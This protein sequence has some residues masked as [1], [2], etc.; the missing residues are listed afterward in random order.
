MRLARALLLAC[1]LLAT[2]AVASETDVL[3]E[4]EGHLWAG[5]GGIGI[6][7][8]SETAPVNA[9]LGVGPISHAVHA[10]AVDCAR[11]VAAEVTWTSLANA[12]LGVREHALLQ[13]EL[14]AANGSVIDATFDDDGDAYLGSDRQLDPGTY[15]LHLFHLAGEPIDYAVLVEG[16]FSGSC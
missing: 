1:L 15:E 14:R 7:A 6:G 5:T 3:L 11:G 8:P 13:A 9:S 16:L 10:F 4:I 2:P 12:T